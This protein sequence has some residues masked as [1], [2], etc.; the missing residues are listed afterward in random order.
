[1]HIPRVRRRIGAALTGLLSALVLAGVAS[2]AYAISGGGIPSYITVQ[3][4]TLGFGSPHATLTN[5][6]GKLCVNGASPGPLNSYGFISLSGTTCSIAGAQQANLASC[7]HLTTGAYKV[8]FTAAYTSLSP[9]CTDS[10]GAAQTYVV[11]SLGTASITLLTYNSSG[12][13]VDMT[14]D[15]QIACVGT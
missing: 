3:Q 10:A 9:I 5:C 8:T 7:S 1:M 6:S 15:F 11:I 14:G 2:V 13:N 12:T 4:L